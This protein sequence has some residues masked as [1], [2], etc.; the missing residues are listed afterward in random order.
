MRE[1]P[2]VEQYVKQHDEQSSL[3]L[4]EQ[5]SG[6]NNIIYHILKCYLCKS[7][8]FFHK[9]SLHLSVLRFLDFKSE[10]LNMREAAHVI[11]DTATVI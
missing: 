2:S 1:A 7:V 9:T 4:W 10:I 11:H 5:I 6:H 3:I 8:S